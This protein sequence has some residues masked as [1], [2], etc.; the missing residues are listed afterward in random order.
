MA[1]EWRAG[2]DEAALRSE[3]DT[4]EADLQGL[5]SADEMENWRTTNERAWREGSR[6]LFVP[7]FYALGRKPLR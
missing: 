7:T 2:P 4:M 5:A 1:S 6:V 3:A